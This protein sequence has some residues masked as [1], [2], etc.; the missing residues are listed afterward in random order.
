MKVQRVEQHIIKKSNINFKMLDDMCFASKN[1]YNYVLYVLRQ[2]YTKKYENIQE[3]RDLIKN[4]KFID[5][6]DLSLRMAKIKQKDFCKLDKVQTSQQIIKLV[7]KNM[8]SFY[9]AIKKYSIN[10]SN[11]LGIPKLP[12][13]K[14]KKSGRNIV[15]FTN[16]SCT[17]K[18][19]EIYFTKFKKLNGIKTNIDK[20][21]QIRIIH[22][23]YYIVL[24]IVY[25]KEIDDN[26]NKNFE[27][28]IGIDLGVNNLASITSDN[29]LSLIIN[30]RILKSINQFY[31]KET[32]RLKS[33]YD[34]QGIKTGKKLQLINLKRNNKIKDYLH[35]SSRFITNL[36][37]KNKIKQVFIRL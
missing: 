20:F 10:K 12:K 13:Y 28:S 33:I 34:K 14:D 5:E 29:G 26:K 16:Q 18:H 32:S 30:G 31:N 17:I 37:L 7:Y 23:G 36:C 25:N 2:A 4:E 21:Q 8:K 11:F 1:L 9:R 27:S 3:Y 22:K 24:E 19:N 15:I 35:K 6:Y